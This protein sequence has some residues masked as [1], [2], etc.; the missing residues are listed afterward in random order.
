M[1]DLTKDP[2]WR[3][4]KKMWRSYKLARKNQDNDKQIK[5]AKAICELQ[6][7]LRLQI[8]EFSELGN[9]VLEK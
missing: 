8:S 3:L 9:E 5:Y 7:E 1:N 2:S 6:H 4:L